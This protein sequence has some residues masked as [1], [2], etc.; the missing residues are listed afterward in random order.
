MNPWS[1]SWKDGMGA[2]GKGSLRNGALGTTGLNRLI[3][4]NNAS[5]NFDRF[6]SLL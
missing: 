4:K 2:L 5:I 1:S 3:D 6:Y